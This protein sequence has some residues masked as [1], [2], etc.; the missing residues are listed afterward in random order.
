MIED[1]QTKLL[2]MGHS[3]CLCLCY[4]YCID[5]DPETL[6]YKYDELVRNKII[7]EDC[8][9]L[10]GNKFLKAFS[11]SKKVLRVPLDDKNYDLY[12]ARFKYNSIAHFSVV[13]KF[14]KVV[15]NPFYESTAVK[16]G[17]IVEK[18]ALTNIVE[19]N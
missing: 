14:N 19:K 7:T 5:V 18:R 16:Y 6:V 10:D 1:L 9:V 12:I 13:D 17:D 3:G 4:L 2:Y 15:Y 11:S 8:Y